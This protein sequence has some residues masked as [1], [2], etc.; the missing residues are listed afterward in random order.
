[1]KITQVRG[2]SLTVIFFDAGMSQDFAWHGHQKGNFCMVDGHVEFMKM[3][4][5][6][7]DETYKWHQMLALAN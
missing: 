4:S 7:P 3:P 1:M 5:D 2:S 6:K